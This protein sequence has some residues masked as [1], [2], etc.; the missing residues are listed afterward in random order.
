MTQKWTLTKAF[1]Y[2]DGAKARNPRW[3]WSARSA[4]GRTVVVT[5]WKDSICDDGRTVTVDAFDDGSGRLR[6]WKDAQG[7][8]DRIQNLVWARDH[9]DGLFRVV[10]VVAKDTAAVPRAIDER[11]PD[12]N[13]VMKLIRLN[14]DTGELLAKGKRG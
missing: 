5:L 4:D 6:L 13:L 1:A 3:S 2:F 12:P 11:Y 8:R 9:C 7:N 10:L 14:E